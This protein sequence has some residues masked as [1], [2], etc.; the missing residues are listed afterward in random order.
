MDTSLSRIEILALETLRGLP[1]PFQPALHS[2]AL[3]VQDLPAPEMLES[4]AIDDPLEL[5][6]LYDGIPMTQK[7]HDE[8]EQGPDVIWLFRKP[9]LAELDERPEV[10][11]AELVHHIMIHELAH[12][13]GWSDDDIA[14]VDEWWT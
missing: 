3:Q 10:T 4:L 8:V 13:F 14:E 12:H 1:A 11:L 6:G 7:S 2:V 5:T 9:I